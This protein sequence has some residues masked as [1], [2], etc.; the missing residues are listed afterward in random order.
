MPQH[1]AV[2]KNPMRRMLWRVALPFAVVGFGLAGLCFFFS[3]DEPESLAEATAVAA[4]AA[5][6]PP[7][8]LNSRRNRGIW[9]LQCTLTPWPVNAGGQPAP[10]LRFELT[11]TLG[12]QVRLRHVVQP[13]FQVTFQL[14]DANDA[15]VEVFYWGT[16]ALKKPVA[17]VSGKS[18]DVDAVYTLN[19]G[20]TYTTALYLS[21]LQEHFEVPTGPGLYKLEAIFDSVGHL[22][23]EDLLQRFVGNTRPIQVDVAAKAPGESRGKWKLIRE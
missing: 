4:P 17:E 19:T 18:D 20:E 6:P 14:R 22:G 16:L 9:Q 3:P 10:D 21:T 11:N 2:T 5:R 23:K 8:V 1:S 12:Q 15:V 13:H 7:G